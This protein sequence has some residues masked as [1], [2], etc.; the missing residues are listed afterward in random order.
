MT[1]QPLDELGVESK[2]KTRVSG[3]LHRQSPPPAHI[4]RCRK[5]SGN[6]W[7]SIRLLSRPVTRITLGPRCCEGAFFKCVAQRIE[8]EDTGGPQ[9]ACA[10]EGDGPH[11]VQISGEI[12]KLVAR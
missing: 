4:P 1:A 8:H 12:Y 2:E 10:L 11:L 9:L 5:T 6:W 7:G 3:G